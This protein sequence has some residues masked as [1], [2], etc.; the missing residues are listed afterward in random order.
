MHT[1]HEF[2]MMD[3]DSAVLASNRVRIK[4]QTF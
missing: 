4:P 1:V 2:R 3:E